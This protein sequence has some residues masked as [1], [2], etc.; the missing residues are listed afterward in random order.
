MKEIHLTQGKVALVDDEDYELLNKYKWCA[1]KDRNIFYTTRGITIQSQNKA[2]N[3]K[4]KTKIIRMHRLIM[5]GK[6]KSNK[7]ID[8]INGN[9][10]DNRRCNLRI[11]TR[12]Q[13]NMNQKKTRGTSKYK[14]VSWHKNNKKWRSQIRLNGKQMYLG[15]FDNEAEAAKA[16]DKRAKELFGEF[17]KPNFGEN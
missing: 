11:V 2:K 15:L 17:A 16:Y 5:K 9:S 8:H 6:L 4:Q 14:G 12:S 10:L 1:K 13:N 7:E 3:I